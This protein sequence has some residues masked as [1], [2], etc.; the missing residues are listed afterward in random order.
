MVLLLTRKGKGFGLG[1]LKRMEVLRN[2][3]LSKG[4][5]VDLLLLEEFTYE[6][7]N[8]DVILTDAREIDEELVRNLV[9]SGKILISLDD[10]ETYKPYVVSVF[11]LPHFGVCWGANF[12]GIDYLILNP[13][14]LE[15]EKS[16]DIDILITFGGED[17]NNLTMFVLKNFSE[18]LRNKRVGVYVGELF[19]YTDYLKELKSFVS[20]EI[21]ESRYFNIHKLIGC[22]DVIITSFGITVYEALVLGKK[23][24]LFNNSEY[25]HNITLMSGLIGKGVFEVG[26]LDKKR[27][28]FLNF[29]ENI[30]FSI[31]TIN[32]DVSRNLDRWYSLVIRVLGLK[33]VD[34]S[35]FW[36]SV[37]VSRSQNITVFNVG[38]NEFELC[39]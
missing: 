29:P 4:I 21:F 27:F 33:G 8:Y 6:V 24:L 31:P 22:S 19:K 15:V 25:H 5:K 35:K 1:H 34:I 39:F 14:L 26:Y 16:R 23:V 30:D 12:D 20:F 7:R 38:S 2:F 32:I 9:R 10:I 28:V 37:V 18:F 11:S 13:Y 3:L 36:D 17:P